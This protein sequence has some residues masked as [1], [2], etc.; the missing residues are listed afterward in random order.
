MLK[1]VIHLDIQSGRYLACGLFIYSAGGKTR[2]SHFYESEK[3]KNISRDVRNV[4]CK[5]CLKTE[6]AKHHSKP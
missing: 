5:R 3:R 6:I 1:P 4:T 2:N